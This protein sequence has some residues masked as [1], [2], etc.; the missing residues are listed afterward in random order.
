MEDLIAA[1]ADDADVPAEPPEL[2]A[3]DGDA[4]D[5]IELPVRGGAR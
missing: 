5:V 2:L 4:P 1:A 3:L